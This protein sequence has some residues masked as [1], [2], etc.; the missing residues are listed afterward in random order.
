MKFADLPRRK[1]EESKTEI[2]PSGVKFPVE[3]P[4]KRPLKAASGETVDTV[5][6]REPGVGDLER[7]D[8][9]SGGHGKMIRLIADLSEHA[10]D[11]IRKLSAADYR[12]MQDTLGAFL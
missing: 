9:G 3:F 12:D 10:P 4:L 1:A 5:T 2:D 11:D 8:E 7:A 6:L